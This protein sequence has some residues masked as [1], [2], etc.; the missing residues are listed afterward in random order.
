MS[1]KVFHPEEMPSNSQSPPPP[2]HYEI[3]SISKALLEA[4]TDSS[5]LLKRAYYRALLRH[6]PDKAAAWSRNADNFTI[7]QISNA[8]TVLSNPSLREA[9]DKS[10][11]VGSD[12]RDRD[13][14]TGIEVVDLDDLPFDETHSRWY[15]SCRCGNE[16]GYRF[17]EDD[18]LEAADDGELLVGCEDCSLWLSVQFAILA[19]GEIPPDKSSAG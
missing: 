1:Y 17:T 14:Q 6:H 13:F 11:G 4:H 18:L 5:R 10:L 12:R 2:T 7:D 15:R 16:S 3:L 8:F 9:Y 19:E